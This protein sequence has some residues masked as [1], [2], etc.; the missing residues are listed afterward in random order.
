MENTYKITDELNWERVKHCT[1]SVQAHQSFVNG[2]HIGKFAGE[3]QDYLN[4]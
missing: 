4:E 2:I 3:F 1:V